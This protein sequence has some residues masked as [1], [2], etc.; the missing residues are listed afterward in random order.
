M[1][2]PLFRFLFDVTGAFI[3]WVSKGFKGKF[4]D[5]MPRPYESS[6]KSWRNMIVSVV[7]I[8]AVFVIVF[9]ISGNTKKNVRNDKYELI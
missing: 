6:N 1:A 3:V 2:N 8:L 4:E 7:F 5:E 9:K